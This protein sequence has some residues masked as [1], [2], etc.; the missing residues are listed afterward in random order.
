VDLYLVRH[1][2]AAPRDAVQW[3]DDSRRPLT[4]EG[5]AR[6]RS[7]ARGLA[8]VVPTVDRLLSSAYTRAWET[9]EILR[10]EA[11]W[12]KPEPAPALEA[13]RPPEDVHELLQRVGTTGSVGL[14]GHEPL[15]SMLASRLLTGEDHLVR[16]ELKKG[17]VL[18]LDV[19]V[20]PG[21]AAVL[22]WSV[23]PRILRSLDPERKPSRL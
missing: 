3:P 19:A 22:R 4:P 7:A 16:L 21:Q 8:T 10:D 6:F 14:V 20:T 15:L 17:G 5:A 2:I 13:D 11:G 9:A 23:S 12:P 1:A 18:L